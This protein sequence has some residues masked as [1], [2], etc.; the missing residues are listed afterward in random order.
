MSREKREISQT[1]PP[2]SL[3]KVFSTMS[4]QGILRSLEDPEQGPHIHLVLLLITIF[5]ISTI[6][7]LIT[8]L[9]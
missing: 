9:L 8:T 1:A 2:F 3:G 6:I 7:I 5:L 4:K